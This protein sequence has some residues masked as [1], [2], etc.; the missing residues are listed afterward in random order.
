MGFPLS[1]EKKTGTRV[2]PLSSADPAMWRKRRIEDLVE[3]VNNHPHQ[4]RRSLSGWDLTLLG[5]GAIVGAGIFVITG[6]AAATKA[7]PAL[8]VSFV[9]SGLACLFTALVYAEFASSVPVSGSA[10]TYAYVSLGEFAAWTI[11]WNL[12]LEY[13]VSAGAVA[14][15]WSGYF[16]RVFQDFG[17]VFPPQWTRAPMEG[18]W[19]NLPAAGIILAISLVLAAGVRESARFNNLVVALKLAVILLFLFVGLRHVNPAHWHPFMPYGWSGV[20]GGAAL[21][22]F[23]YIGFD[24]VST[25][26]EEAKNPQRDLPIGILGSLGICTLL[27]ILVVLVLTGMV[28]YGSLNVSDPVAFALSRVGEGLIAGW[29]SAGAI[30]GLT[31]VLLVMMYGQ[32]RIFFAM[33]RDGLLPPVFCRVH[34]KFGTPVWVILVTGIVVALIAGLMPIQEV[35]ELTNIG[36]LAAF[37]LVSIGVLVVRHTHPDLPRPFRAPGMP[38]TSLL[39][40]GSC[41]YLVGHLAPM[42]LWRFVIWSILGF[43]LYFGYARKRSHIAQENSSHVVG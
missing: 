25:A 9:V 1:S 29:V 27:Y 3:R 42:T 34:E 28:P 33:A 40:A 15:G 12:I 11:G 10:Y 39:A 35:A 18:G 17:L 32:S 8:S 22:F 14:I 16:Q 13:A 30:A 21:I 4:L 38:W 20:M 2:S 37:I 19:I 23:A 6:I 41:L 31:S 7:G 43:I 5:I 26:A 24:A 36:T